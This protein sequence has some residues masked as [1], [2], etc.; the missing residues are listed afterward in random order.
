MKEPI[1]FG[2]LWVVCRKCNRA[3]DILQNIDGMKKKNSKVVYSLH[4]PF[5]SH[6]ERMEIKNEKETKSISPGKVSNN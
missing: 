3:Y 1:T 5:C 4:C 6:N 2:N